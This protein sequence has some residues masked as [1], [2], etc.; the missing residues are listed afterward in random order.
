MN[1]FL[2]LLYE[3]PSRSGAWG[4]GREMRATV[5][6]TLEVYKNESDNNKRER[7]QRVGLVVK[8]KGTG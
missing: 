6:S 3:D 1:S 8:E 2:P 7:E 4:V 5:D